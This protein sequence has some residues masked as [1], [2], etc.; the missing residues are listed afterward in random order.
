MFA[1]SVCFPPSFL[2]VYIL[3]RVAVLYNQDPFVGRC[4]KDQNLGLWL[5]RTSLH[6]G[7]GVKKE[8]LEEVEEWLEVS[9]R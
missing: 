2:L 4:L 3:C 5:P 7:G 6:L 1:L 8:C 9:D